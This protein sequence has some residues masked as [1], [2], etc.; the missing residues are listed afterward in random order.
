MPPRTGATLANR[1]ENAD[2]GESESETE[3]ENQKP[4]TKN[5]P[6][7]AD[8]IEPLP[9]TNNIIHPI[10]E[11][12]IKPA[13]I[14]LRAEHLQIHFRT[15][16]SSKSSFGM[17]HEP[18]TNP[19]TPLSSQHGKRIKPSTMPIVP[20]HHRA[21]DK[22]ILNRNEEQLGLRPE[23]IHDRQMRITLRPVR[24]PILR[25][26]F[27]PQRNHSI[28]VGRIERADRQWR[29]YHSVSRIDRS[30]DII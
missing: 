22:S 4:K 28:G 30:I 6:S 26:R 24:I 10:P 15:T 25:E 13:H 1:Y 2:A 27:E 16:A 11:R 18:R 29:V 9:K 12:L 14:G 3:N 17:L 7:V 20:S 23:L 5:L 8:K 21:D 19:M